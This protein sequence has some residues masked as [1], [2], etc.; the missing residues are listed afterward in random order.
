MG[1]LSATALPATE[2]SEPA[3]QPVCGSS[4]FGGRTPVPARLSVLARRARLRPQQGSARTVAPAPGRRQGPPAG[5]QL[6]ERGPEAGASACPNAADVLEPYPEL[7]S[8]CGWTWWTIPCPAGSMLYGC[9]ATH[10]GILGLYV[11]GSQ[12]A[13]LV[14]WPAP[15]GTGGYS[16]AP[17]D[18]QLTVIR[19][20]NM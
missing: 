8:L 13:A 3:G 11:H 10:D 12:D 14:R 18:A 2:P 5:P 6:G 19:Y 1:E 15:D 17:L 7:R 20:E 9:R 4:G 16:R